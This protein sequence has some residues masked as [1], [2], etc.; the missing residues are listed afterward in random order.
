M[1][2]DDARPGPA[3]IELRF[4]YRGERHLVPGSLEATEYIELPEQVKGMD[5][6]A[7]CYDILSE[8]RKRLGVK[9][10]YPTLASDAGQ[11]PERGR[12]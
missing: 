7:L 12:G 4:S 1:T 11:T 10:V 6:L 2:R 9:S 5:A 3:V 8:F